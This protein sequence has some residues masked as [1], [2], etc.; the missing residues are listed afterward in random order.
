MNVLLN[1]MRASIYLSKTV[2]A[3][4]MV[5][6]IGYGIHKFV[7]DQRNESRKIPRDRQ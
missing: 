1:I 5:I 2:S 4:G 6:V 3:I 7:K